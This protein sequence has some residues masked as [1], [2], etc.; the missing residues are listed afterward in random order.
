ML[1]GPSVQSPPGL[2]K[3]DWDDVLRVAGRVPQI[4]AI[5]IAVRVTRAGGASMTVTL[6]T[7]RYEIVVAR[8]SPNVR[9]RVDSVRIYD[10]Q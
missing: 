4:D 9:W 3:D 6:Y 2:P 10:T 1:V 8:K 5:V 7:P